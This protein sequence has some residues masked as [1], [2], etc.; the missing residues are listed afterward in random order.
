MS[1][2]HH[3]E[4]DAVTVVARG[5]IDLSTAGDLQREIEAAVAG[6]A[7]AVTVDLGEVTF[8]DS[9]GIN[10]LLTGRR[11]ADDHRKPYRV[12]NAQGMVR[13]LLRLTGVWDHLSAPA[14]G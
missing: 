2:P 12:T 5:E 7:S 8:L 1:T 10:A 11:F 3:R 6:P 9:A 14:G 13:Q 4:T